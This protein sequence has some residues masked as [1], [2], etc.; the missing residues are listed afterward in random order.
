[1]PHTLDRNPHDRRHW[2]VLDPLNRP[3]T[4]LTLAVERMAETGIAE[5]TWRPYARGGLRF[6]DWYWERTVASATP[7]TPWD[8]EEQVRALIDSA[9]VSLNGTITTSTTEPD[10]RHIAGSDPALEAVADLVSGTGYLYEGLIKNRHYLFPN[11]IMLPEGKR[12]PAFLPLL[13][14]GRSSRRVLTK[15]YYR[16]AGIERPGPRVDD[17]TFA[18]RMIEALERFRNM[19]RAVVLLV[20]IA[21]WGLARLSEQIGLTIWDWWKAS[22]FR[23]L[24]ATKNKGQGELPVKE[25]LIPDELVDELT[26]W[27]NGDR[28]ALDRYDRSLDDWATFLSD[29]TKTLEERKSEALATPLIPNKRK[30]FYSPSGIRDVWFA[31]AMRKAGLITRFHFIRHAGVCDAYAMIDAMEI[32]EEQ[33][34][35]KKIAFGRQLGWAWPERMVE[36]YATSQIKTVEIEVATE[37][38][39]NRRAH[40]ALIANGEAPPRLTPKVLEHKD[41]G[42]LKQLFGFRKGTRHASN[43][44]KE[45]A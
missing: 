36:W 18:G 10:V 14:G 5:T 25:Q 13:N 11:P 39:R 16:V 35:K 2:L 12:K 42:P 38:Q 21:M 9:I 43:S 34:T 17:P 20:K 15:F 27:G 31:P 37:W 28:V 44:L 32:S 3:D 7:F 8:P 30:G 33:K 29:E 22:R 23:N 24:I 40:L 1:M 26:E 45:A 41:D 6:F 19:P 4:R